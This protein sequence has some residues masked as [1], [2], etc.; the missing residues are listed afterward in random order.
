MYLKDF[1]E[2]NKKVL[3][4]LRFIAVMPKINFT[5]TKVYMA[6][7]KNFRNTVIGINQLQQLYVALYLSIP[8]PS[9]AHFKRHDNWFKV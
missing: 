8:N 1:T 4:T 3:K 7:F 2:Q 5:N 6:K 9:M